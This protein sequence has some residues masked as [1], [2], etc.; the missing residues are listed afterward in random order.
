MKKNNHTS[1]S[2]FT[3]LA[4]KKKKKRKNARAQNMKRRPAKLMIT[5][6]CLPEGVVDP[7]GHARMG[8]HYFHTGV[9]T[10]ENLLVVTYTISENG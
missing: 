6:V 3:G 10:S 9:R 2:L 8:G 5:L 7:P 4:T 1:S